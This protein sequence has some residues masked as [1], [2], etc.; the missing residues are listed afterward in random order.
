MAIADAR[1]QFPKRGKAAAAKLLRVG[2]LGKTLPGVGHRIDAAQDRKESRQRPDIT[3]QERLGLGVW[4]PLQVAAQSVDEAVECL[5][6][7][8][9]PFVTTAFQ[10]DHLRVALAQLFE[11]A[12]DQG[13]L[14]HPRPPVQVDHLGATE[15]GRIEGALEDSQLR[16]AADEWRALPPAWH[17]RLHA[18][19]RPHAAQ[20]GEHFRVGGPHR[21]PPLEEV[22]AQRVEPL[23]NALTHA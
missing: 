13:R 22:A 19:R 12:A 17:G 11:K 14:A 15:R 1:Q 4:K 23:R 3:R 10:D 8:R 16:A 18:G 9:L 2:H 6:W 7:H 5:V 21:R 20:P